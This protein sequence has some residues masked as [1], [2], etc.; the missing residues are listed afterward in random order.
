MLFQIITK[1][2]FRWDLHF[3]WK[4]TELA[5]TVSIW[6]LIQWES[7]FIFLGGGRKCSK[8]H[9]VEKSEQLLLRKV[10]IQR[11]TPMNFNSENIQ[12]LLYSF[13]ITIL[14]VH[15]LSTCLKKFTHRTLIIMTIEMHLYYIGSLLAL[16]MLIRHGK[17]YCKKDKNYELYS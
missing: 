10:K 16:K 4:Y 5:Y 7:T 8:G 9:E 2:D 1:C 3:L 14:C 11:Y 12:Y 17:Q 13:F 6:K 15:V